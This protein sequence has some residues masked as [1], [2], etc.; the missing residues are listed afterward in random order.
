KIAGLVGRIAYLAIQINPSMIGKVK[1]WLGIEGVKLELRLPEGQA[2]VNGSLRGQIVI[3]SKHAQTITGV[4]IILIER[5]AR[6][7]GEERLVDEYQ[8]GELTLNETFEIGAEEELS[9]DFQLDFAA[10]QSPV[11]A[12]GNKNLV[13]Q[14]LAKAARWLRSAT[15]TYRVEAEAKV[16]G[17][18]LNPFDK[19]KVRLS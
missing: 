14:Q 11:D 15:S 16:K 9:R 1:Q 8:L 4:R 3:Q 18:A 19:K 13:N 6:G 5:Y 2:L 12:W 17:V 10:L 7:R